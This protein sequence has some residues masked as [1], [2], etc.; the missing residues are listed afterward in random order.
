M[1]ERDFVNAMLDDDDDEMRRLVFADW[2]EENGQTDHAEWV[3][4]S[5]AAS[6]LG[7]FEPGHIAAVKYASETWERCR[8]PWWNTAGLS[9]IYESADRGLMRLHVQSKTAVTRLGKLNWLLRAFKEGWLGWISVTVIEESVA[10][11]LVQWKEPARRI[12]VQLCLRPPISEALLLQLAALPRLIWVELEIGSLLTPSIGRLVERQ[13][14]RWMALQLGLNDFRYRV[15]HEIVSSLM[16]RVG[17][18]DR[19]RILNLAGPRPNPSDPAYLSWLVR[20]TGLRRLILIDWPDLTVEALEPLK[21]MVGLR[22]LKLLGCPV[23]TDVGL[24]RVRDAFP[25]LQVER[26]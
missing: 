14:V 20:M 13:D 15:S 21:A 24:L 3:R 17:R 18:L 7:P 19:L 23:S 2:L 1:D 9:G 22:E 8:P 25:M 11:A 12:P 16:D 26:L 10:Q 4:A 5:C 6:R